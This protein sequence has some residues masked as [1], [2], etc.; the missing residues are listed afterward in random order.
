MIRREPHVESGGAAFE[1]EK[2]SAGVYSP[3]VGLTR[4]SDRLVRIRK[5]RRGEWSPTT[6]FRATTGGASEGND[7][8]GAISDY[9][10]ATWEFESTGADRPGRRGFGFSAADDADDF[11]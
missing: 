1:F 7:W 4:S 3:P 10:S 9:D 8:S 2:R 5:P 6:G 11:S